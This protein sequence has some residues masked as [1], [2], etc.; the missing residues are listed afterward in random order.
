MAP[1]CECS[2]GALRFAT[3]VN[4]V[5]IVCTRHRLSRSVLRI[6]ETYI[7]GSL[8]AFD[9]LAEV[10]KFNE[11]ANTSTKCIFKKDETH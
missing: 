3:Q 2:S 1:F 6:A 5:K 7:L 4:V 11:V 10:K 9:V 8:K